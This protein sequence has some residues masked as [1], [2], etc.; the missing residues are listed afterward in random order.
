MQITQSSTSHRLRN[1]GHNPITLKQAGHPAD[2]GQRAPA[3]L[4]AESMGH[5]GPRQR[6]NIVSL[7]F[8]Q[9][10]AAINLLRHT[11]ACRIPTL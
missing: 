9:P 11:H 3:V 2:T 7:P 4:H 8:W 1:G 6:R 5:A 10:V